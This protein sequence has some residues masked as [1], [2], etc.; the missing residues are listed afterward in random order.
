MAD[1][2]DDA[3]TEE[4]GR[5]RRDILDLS[6]C[7]ATGP[8]IRYKRSLRCAATDTC[9][10]MQATVAEYS[11]PGW[12]DPVDVDDPDVTSKPSPERERLRVTPDEL[13]TGRGRRDGMWWVGKVVGERDLVD[14]LAGGTDWAPAATGPGPC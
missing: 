7:E 12:V 1:R 11:Y 4:C 2:P 14:K 13:G 6:K 5:V 10:H 8:D 9:M 3:E